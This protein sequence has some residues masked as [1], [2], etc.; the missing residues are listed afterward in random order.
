MNIPKVEN[1]NS[2]RS[3]HPVANQYIITIDGDKYFQSYRTI[4]A[5]KK[6][7]GTIVLDEN[8][9][10]YSRTTAK[11]RNEFLNENTAETRKK[12]KDGTYKLEN[13]N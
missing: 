3:G 12:I 10:N 11:Y 9:W 4:I 7:D 6:Y 13:L 2:P 1:M 5:V 8:D